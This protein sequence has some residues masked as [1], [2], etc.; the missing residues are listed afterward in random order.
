MEKPFTIVGVV[1]A[2]CEEEEVCAAAELAE[3]FTGTPVPHPERVDRK[4]EAMMNV[5]IH[6]TKEV[7]LPAMSIL[8]PINGWLA[9]SFPDG[10]DCPPPALVDY[11]SHGQ[12][13]GR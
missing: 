2:G 3:G 11:F 1:V 4:R 13:D 5:Q 9:A 12:V 7:E 10:K 6:R 8:S